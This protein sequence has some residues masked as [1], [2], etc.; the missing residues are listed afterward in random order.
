MQAFRGVNATKKSLQLTTASVHHVTKE[1]I[2]ASER[3]KL[4]LESAEPSESRVVLVSLFIPQPSTTVIFIYPQ[5][6]QGSMNW[7]L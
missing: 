7:H 6:S 5:M 3:H 2:G 1:A 4:N